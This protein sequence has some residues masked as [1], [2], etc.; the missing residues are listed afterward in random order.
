MEKAK[1]NLIICFD[2]ED[3]KY[4]LS[5]ET[6]DNEYDLILNIDKNDLL[7]EVLSYENLK[8]FLIDER[9]V[10]GK[11]GRDQ[12]FLDFIKFINDI[13]DKKINILESFDTVSFSSL[14]YDDILQ[15][16][17]KNK[18]LKDKN[19]RLNENDM[20]IN[21][22][23]KKFK[24]YKNISFLLTG[25]QEIVSLEDYEKTKDKIEQII[26]IIKKYDLS[27][28]EEVM[29]AYDIVRDR[30]YKEEALKESD[31]N[32]RDLSRV[33]LGDEIV[34]EGYA[35]LFDE[36]LNRLAIKSKRY[37]LDSKNGD[38]G[39]VRNIAFIKD[40][41]Y[42]IDGIYY[43]DT[44]WD[45]RRS[46][47][48][49]NYL[50]SYKYFAKQKGDFCGIDQKYGLSDKTF[51]QYS[52]NFVWEFKSIV[53]E[54]GISSVP[55]SMIMTINKLSDFIDE[56]RSKIQYYPFILK[57]MMP[58]YSFDIKIDEKK[59]I[60]KLIEYTALLEQPIDAYKMLMILHK[61]R[62]CENM[63]DEKKYP[64]RVGDFYKI[65]KISGW[66]F[67][68]SKNMSR[69]EEEKEYLNTIGELEFGVI[70]RKRDSENV[71]AKKKTKL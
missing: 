41:K 10:L 16:L 30:I 57:K 44:T 37:Y 31:R 35:T 29:F 51:L 6:N 20:S 18:I 19:I 23:R 70:S 71:R 58:N 4:E 47:D 59:V 66:K 5:R 53:E 48:D 42:D 7:S 28:M 69:E 36:I 2:E 8:E 13:L 54:K 46:V 62:T 50:L 14:N 17:N 33:L 9:E 55:D 40:D 43:F 27:P 11:M 56:G 49:K 60:D 26:N 39:H 38:A 68:I 45:S 63:E 34:C 67:D 21:L 61:V 12:E 64:F 22:I 15:F 32:S 25:N 65:L 52:K 3:D 1:C 24:D